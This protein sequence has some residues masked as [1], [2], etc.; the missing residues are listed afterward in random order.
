MADPDFILALSPPFVGIQKA[1]FSDIQDS[2][3]CP[4]RE[5]VENLSNLLCK[6]CVVHARGTPASGK[7]F[8]A[9][10]LHNFLLAQNRQVLTLPS[11]KPPLQYGSAIDYL[12]GA[13]RAANIIIPS[14]GLGACEVIII[15]DEAQT[16]YTDETLWNQLIK[17]RHQLRSGL[18]ICLF[19]FYG[20]PNCGVDEGTMSPGTLCPEQRISLV[21]HDDGPGF[22][23][24]YTEAECR[25]AIM[26]NKF[27]TTSQPEFDDDAV[28]QIFSVTNGHPG[29][30]KALLDC[31]EMVSA[32]YWPWQLAS[33]NAKAVL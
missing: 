3:V 11:W 25:D 30:V 24:F 13:C 5:V 22:G 15:I 18:R 8:L 6:T 14:N 17:D 33:A 9:K 28:A 2:Y 19:S 16:S 21:P 1:P 29:M 32:V 31:L 7:S 27:P 4:R 26:R 20:S 12:T 10:L 23:L